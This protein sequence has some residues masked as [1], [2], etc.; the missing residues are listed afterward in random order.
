M[1]KKEDPKQ[2]RDELE[3]DP[4]TVKDLE[5]DEETA[6]QVQGGGT[7][8]TCACGPDPTAPISL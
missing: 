6:E 2:E 4:K 7:H 8:H 3:L 5:V 1:G